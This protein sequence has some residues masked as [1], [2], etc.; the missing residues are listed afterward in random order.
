M[1]TLG[2]EE[3][4]EPLRVYL[5]KYREVR[6]TPAC[7]RHFSSS[8]ADRGCAALFVPQ[9]EVRAA[10]CALPHS[11][12]NV[13]TAFAAQ[14]EKASAAKAGEAKKGGDMQFGMGFQ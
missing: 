2:F 10:S 12:C 8:R 1:S 3:Y 6:A 11:R 14:G 7:A 4:V 13:L 9:T 5:Q